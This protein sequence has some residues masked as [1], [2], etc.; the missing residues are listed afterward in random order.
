MNCSA[1]DS[2][3]NTGYS[4]FKVIV[5]YDFNGFFKPIDNLPV[6]N[7]TKAGQ[8]I[9]VKFS[10]GGNMGLNIFA[11]AYP[12][13]IQMACGGSAQ[14]AIEETTTAGGSSLSYDATTGQY[15]YVWKTEKGWAG[16]C[17]QLQVKLKDGSI[18]SANFNFTR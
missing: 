8:A 2:H 5:S 10:L 17:R 11:A 16:T 3:G 4:S 7:V 15:I 13:S 18:R 1:T 9:P 12:R 14:D 6:V